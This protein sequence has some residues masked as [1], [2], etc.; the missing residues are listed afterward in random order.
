M[1]HLHSKYFKAGGAHISADQI[2]QLLDDEDEE[3]LTTCSEVDEAML[4]KVV[5]SN[6]GEHSKGSKTSD[7]HNAV[8][9]GRDAALLKAAAA[10]KE[11]V[12]SMMV[13]KGANVETATV[14][15]DTPLLRA[16]AANR[17]AAV[18]RLIALGANADHANMAGST[19]L[20]I[21]ASKGHT[22]VVNELLAGGATVDLATWWGDT[23]LINAALHGHPVVV[24]LLLRHGALVDAEN[25][26]GC[27]AIVMAARG[28]HCQAIDVLLEHGASVD[29][30]TK[31]GD[32]A[33]LKAAACGHEL[34]VATLLVGGAFANHRNEWGDTALTIAAM[35][36]HDV[37]V[38]RLLDSG[39]D[40]KL[41]NKD[42]KTALELARSK[43]H[44]RC[45]RLLQ[46]AERQALRG[47]EAMSFLLT[48]NGG[49]LNSELKAL[50]HSL[51]HA[52]AAAVRQLAS[53]REVW[54][55]LSDLYGVDSMWHK[56]KVLDEA[57]GDYQARVNLTRSRATEEMN[58]K[59][60]LNSDDMAV[61]KRITAAQDSHLTAL[62][63][64][65]RL[66][67]R[68]QAAMESRA[69]QVTQ[70]KSVLSEAISRS[71]EN[72]RADPEVLSCRGSISRASSICSTPMPASPLEGTTPVVGSPEMESPLSGHFPLPLRRL[73]GQLA[74]TVN[75]T[76][77][78][79]A[80]AAAAPEVHL[81]S[82]LPKAPSPP[83]TTVG[84]APNSEPAT[85]PLPDK[86]ASQPVVAHAPALSPLH[87]ST[88]NEESFVETVV[89]AERVLRI[90][91]LKLAPAMAATEKASIALYQAMAEEMAILRM[92]NN[93]VSQVVDRS[94]T[95]LKQVEKNIDGERIL[96]D[97]SATA[98]QAERYHEQLVGAL[99]AFGR[100]LESL[101]GDS[102]GKA[103]GF[104]GSST[105]EDDL[106]VV[107]E[108]K[109]AAKSNMDH[110]LA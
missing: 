102:P 87:D 37:V 52:E 12:V 22:V 60:P 99:N 67:K 41:T 74:S 75:G 10:G 63:E 83:S 110:P 9:T 84:A 25:K 100:T 47:T 86:S 107:P 33:L 31:F 64:I 59:H 15:G 85:P 23:P 20:I 57:I 30:Q 88:V 48:Y 71:V 45:V 21:A 97:A 42:G 4:R 53:L 96:S 36:G 56:M 44:K 32:T 50:L 13:E 54:P 58:R 17:A 11:D 8:N 40:I 61:Q 77:A 16:A 38:E 66:Y 91:R 81:Q 18:T 35:R 65:C 19:A 103:S 90:A 98:V 109:A 78:D 7:M 27:T 68:K 28:N 94:L 95:A 69:Q 34:A 46:M 55:L 26:H 49:R 14:F 43:G 80:A 3:M 6:F 5:E 51:P 2:I 92:V 29:H 82:S 70:M 62:Q 39:A 76:A 72:S 89:D 108:S 73:N 104:V 101:S 24:E 1:G 105:E 93:S 79:P 106:V